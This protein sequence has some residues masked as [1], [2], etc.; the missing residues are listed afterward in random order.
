MNVSPIIDTFV[1]A[2]DDAA[3]STS[4]KCPESDAC[5]PKAVSA[6]VT[7]SEVVARSSPDAAAKF[8]TPSIP[9]IMSF[10]FQPAIAM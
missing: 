1:L 3:A 9:P 5:S 4:A 10:D 7:M 2:F 6:S 8:M